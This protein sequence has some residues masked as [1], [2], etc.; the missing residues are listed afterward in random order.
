M[1]DWAAGA[2]GYRSAA[3]HGVGEVDEGAA[4]HRRVRRLGRGQ[5]ERVGQRDRVRQ[6]GQRVTRRADLDR[7]VTR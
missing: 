1:A 6:Q 2:A 5:R 7:R 4:E 3:D